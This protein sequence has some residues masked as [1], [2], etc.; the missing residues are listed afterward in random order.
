M[1]DQENM[2]WA[3]DSYEMKIYYKLSARKIFPLCLLYVAFQPW[4]NLQEDV[5]VNLDDNYNFTVEV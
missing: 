2:C 4:D 3:S 5:N 1:N